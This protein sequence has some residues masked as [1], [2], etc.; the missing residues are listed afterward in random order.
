MEAHIRQL[1]L[2]SELVGSCI[3]SMVGIIIKLI[4][5]IDVDKFIHKNA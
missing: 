2:S 5:V 1:T 4:D 3:Y